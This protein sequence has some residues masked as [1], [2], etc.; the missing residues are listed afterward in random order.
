MIVATSG[1]KTE[2]HSVRAQRVRIKKT[3]LMYVECLSMEIKTFSVAN[4]VL[5][6]QLIMPKPL[7]TVG[8]FA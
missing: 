6:A 3:I 1:I 7:P 5:Q 8:L 4:T 2:K